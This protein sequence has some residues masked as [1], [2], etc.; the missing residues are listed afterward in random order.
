MHLTRRRF[1]SVTL[2]T[3][4]ILAAGRASPEGAALPSSPASGELAVGVLRNLPGA[5]IGVADEGGVFRK[6]GVAVT[7]PGKFLS[8]GGPALLPAVAAG[9]VD[10]GVIGDTPAI[11]A[12]ARGDLP[13]EIVGVVSDTSRVFTI[14]AA[15]P[16]VSL[17]DLAGKK[18]GLPTGTAFEYFF[19][20]ALAHAGMKPGD[21]EVVNLSQPQA[22]PAFIAKRVDAVLPDT[23]GLRALLK[24]RPDAKAIFSSDGGFATSG[25]ASFRQFNVFVARGE[26]LHAK[27]RELRAFLHTYYTG[28][29]GPL[30]DPGTRGATVARMTG[31]I[32][33]GV[34]DAV[35]SDDLLKQ[36]ELSDFPTLA[37]AR[38]LQAGEFKA[39][40]ETQARFW[41]A[42]GR[43][44]HAPDFGR[45][46]DTSLLA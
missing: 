23:F 1:I 44:Q 15:P 18:I 10:I 9:N 36:V 31:F 14:V 37:R 45:A 21:V 7:L 12:L 39:A 43:I 13:L 32:N 25:A 3:T 8:G 22:L 27:E 38:A 2:A 26:T 29:T 30:N 41:V 40:L 20:S 5:L 33:A 11:L 6:G 16:F 28:V 17:K 46:L 42:S 19:A 34:K 35:N 24:A 4:S